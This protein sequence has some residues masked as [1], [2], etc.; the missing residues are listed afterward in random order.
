MRAIEFKP[1]PRTAELIP[2]NATEVTKVVLI[3]KNVYILRNTDRKAY[4][5]SEKAVPRRSMSLAAWKSCVMTGI[6]VA[7]MVLSGM[8]SPYMDITEER[9]KA[10]GNMLV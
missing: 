7:V 9:K 6:S 8:A 2:K 4:L 10:L 3:S 5:V 1:V